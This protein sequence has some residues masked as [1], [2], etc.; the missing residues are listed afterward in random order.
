MTAKKFRAI[1]FDVCGVLVG[2]RERTRK[3]L[4]HTGT[5]EAMAKK[6]KLNIDSWIDLIETPYNASMEGRM[7]GRR[8]VKKIAGRLGV[9]S[10]KLTEVW[11]SVYRKKVK[12][13][14]KLYKIA[15]SL[16]KN[17]IVGILSDQ[18]YLSKKAFT[19]PENIKG[20][21]PVIISC[22]VGFR[23]PD[24]RIY[25][26]LMKKLR[27]KNKAIKPGEVLF[28]DNRKYNLTP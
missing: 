12:K 25:K 4:E 17:Y 5:Q 23:K 26:L 6:F 24:I 28:V 16:K 13:D 11:L 8:A 18:W 27:E 3:V 9:T 1:I 21:S 20:F 19:P 14:K 10:K 7:N 22:D 2:G 15:Y